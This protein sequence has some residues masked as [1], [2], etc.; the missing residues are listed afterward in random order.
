VESIH[1]RT[2]AGQEVVVHFDWRAPDAALESIAL[3]N[4]L[5][6]R[7]LPRPVWTDQTW[8]GNGVA[9]SSGGL[10]AARALQAALGGVGRLDT[11]LGNTGDKLALWI[12]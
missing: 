7:G 8:P 4:C 3:L 5:G 2:L 1:G 12:R 10:R 6:A 11:K 9:Y